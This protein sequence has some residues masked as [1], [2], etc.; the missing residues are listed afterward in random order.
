MKIKFT[1]LLILSFF[2]SYISAEEL[3]NLS[4]QQLISMQK[5]QKAIVID[6]RT[7]KE[8]SSTGTIPES[9]KLQFFTSDGKYDVDK[10][11]ANLK[12][13]KQS[14][15][16]PVILVCRSGNRSGM[17]GTMLTKQLNLKNI[18][19]LSSGISSWI[20]AGNKVIK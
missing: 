9:H 17:V 5:E 12:K 18:Y 11:L 7:E 15:D 16:Q 20:K 3:T 8:W 13:L 1:L 14:E 19:H 4:T 2:V 10:W 6:I